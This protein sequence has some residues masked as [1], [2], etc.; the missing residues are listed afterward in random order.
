MYQSTFVVS[1]YKLLQQKIDFCFGLYQ[2]L[3]KITKLDS[4]DYFMLHSLISLRSDCLRC[5]LLQAQQDPYL[6]NH[7]HFPERQS[8]IIVLSL[9]SGVQLRSLDARKMFAR[10]AYLYLC[11]QV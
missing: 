7:C 9:F 8:R 1:F 3:I 4:L 5:K 11:S 2:R 10:V 6:S